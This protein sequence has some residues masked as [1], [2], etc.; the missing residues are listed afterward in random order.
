[1]FLL[2]VDCLPFIAHCVKPV[3]ASRYLAELLCALWPLV[4]YFCTL[5]RFDA[6]CNISR[7]PGFSCLRPYQ[8]INNRSFQLEDRLASIRTASQ[9]VSCMKERQV[10][11]VLFSSATCCQSW[12]RPKSSQE[13]QSVPAR[14]QLLSVSHIFLNS[15]RE[16][17]EMAMKSIVQQ[18][19]AQC[20][21]RTTTRYC[22]LND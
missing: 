4:L 16:E 5:Y 6:T 11:T 9:P 8:K 21:N 1:M 10:A 12:H 17:H 3:L 13:K 22:L 7:A 15:R 19:T 20:N 18:L 2:I 14:T